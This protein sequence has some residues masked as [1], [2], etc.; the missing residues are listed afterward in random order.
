MTG[1]DATSAVTIAGATTIDRDTRIG[2]DP[3]L[4][5]ETDPDTRTEIGPG[6]VTGPGMR[7]DPGTAIGTD[8]ATRRDRAGMIGRRGD[9]ATVPR[10]SRSGERKFCS[11]SNQ[12]SFGGDFTLLYI[13]YK[14]TISLLL[15]FI[16][17]FD[18]QYSQFNFYIILSY[19]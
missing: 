15:T 2:G 3:A 19:I 7:I 12:L 18:F 13:I 1:L 10:T 8:R 5:I 14:I 4:R 9:P 17:L 6:V 16:K 11:Y